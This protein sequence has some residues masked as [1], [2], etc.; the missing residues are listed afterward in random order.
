MGLWKAI[1]KGMHNIHEVGTK[2]IGPAVGKAINKG[3]KKAPGAKP[4]MVI[5]DTNNTIY[6]TPTEEL[7]AKL[8]SK[9]NN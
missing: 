2:T 8:K 7:V 3:L 4:G 9:F 1:N 6:V 5:Y